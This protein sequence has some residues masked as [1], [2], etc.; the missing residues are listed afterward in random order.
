MIFYLFL[1][2]LFC[3]CTLFTELHMYLV[4]KINRTYLVKGD[5]VI[6][7]LVNVMFFKDF[8]NRFASIL[9]NLKLNTI[10]VYMPKVITFLMILVHFITQ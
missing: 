4:C 9:I 8:V 7:V 10:I 6:H 1:I 3:P 5:E 2:V